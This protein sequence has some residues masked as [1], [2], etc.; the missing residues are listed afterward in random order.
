VIVQP[1]RGFAWLPARLA[2]P[3]LQARLPRAVRSAGGTAP[4]ATAHGVVYR[5]GLLWHTAGV[6]GVGRARMPSGPRV[7]EVCAYPAR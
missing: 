3:S 1:R 5:L 7:L 6:G 4:A 2:A